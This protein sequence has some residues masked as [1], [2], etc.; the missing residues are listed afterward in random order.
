MGSGFM[1]SLYYLLLVL[2]LTA[3]SCATNDKKQEAK[4]GEL[5]SPAGTK[6]KGYIMKDDITTGTPAFEGDTLTIA[7]TAAV[8]YQPDSLQ[9]QKRMKRVGETD[10]R[11][12]MDDYIYSVNTSVEFLQ[13]QGLPVFD[14]K[15]KKYLKFVSPGKEAQI[16]RLDTL[17]E[18]WGMY[19]FDPKKKPLAVDMTVIEDEYKNYS[20]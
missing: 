11:I 7:K 17:Q 12:G 6:P 5:V 20:Q 4:P 18:L 10:F 13:K 1:Q 8:F 16:V 19:L 2:S 9:I 3:L 15:S 14:A